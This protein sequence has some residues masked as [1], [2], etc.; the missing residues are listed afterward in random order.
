MGGPGHG[1]GHTARRW[2][3]LSF[4]D[5]VGSSRQRGTT[6]HRPLERHGWDQSPRAVGGGEQ[7]LLVPVRVGVGV[8][9]RVY[10]RAWI[11]PGPHTSS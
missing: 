5:G 1:P 4:Q 9:V 7:C 10:T 8:C 11:V 6:T 3:S 2:G